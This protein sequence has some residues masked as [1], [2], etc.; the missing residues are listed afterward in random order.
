[1]EDRSLRE[2]LRR[3]CEEAALQ[4]ALDVRNGV[5][6]PFELVDEAR[7]GGNA[8][9]LWCYRTLTG[10]FI[11]ERLGVLGML[12]TYLPAAQALERVGGIEDWFE[13]RG[14]QSV[15]SSARDRGDA[16]L[17]V[18]LA[19]VIGESAT[20]EFDSQRFDSAWTSLEAIVFSSLST[21]LIAAPIHGLEL[22]SPELRLDGD[23]LLVSQDSVEA[24]V[25]PAEMFR[26]DQP[27]VVAMLEVTDGGAAGIATART[28]LRKLVCALRLSGVTSPALGGAARI[29]IEGGPWQVADIGGAG[30]ADGLMVIAP[31]EEADLRSFCALVERHWPSGGELA[32]ALRR[33]ELGCDRLHHLDA[34]SDH[35]LALRALLEP[36]GPASGQLTARLAALCAVPEQRVSLA[37][38]TARAVEL[39]RLA[40]TG[41]SGREAN[42]EAICEEVR[43]NLR[44]LLRDVICGH[45]DK[46]LCGIADAIIAQS[47]GIADNGRGF[48]DPEPLAA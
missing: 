23:V 24:E 25:L 31:G 18:F 40:M 34:L 45:L 19:E 3:F 21:T 41:R 4:L 47:A 46:D 14:E 9:P 16:A 2:R 15:F 12:P 29:R 32:W 30:A 10:D 17:R 11:R 26:N 43:T 27:V 35:L 33:H 1:V 5:K 39:E 22:G 38:S 42:A 36:E 20:F 37:E 48:G 8:Q 44:A 13:A 6:V 28:R 7:S